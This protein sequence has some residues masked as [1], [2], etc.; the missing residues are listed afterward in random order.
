MSRRQV[1]GARALLAML[2]LAAIGHQFARSTSAGADPMNFFS[3]FTILGNVFVAGVFLA[4]ALRVAER[5]VPTPFEDSVRGA[6]VLYALATGVVYSTLLSHFELGLTLPWVNVQLHYVMP[7]A[8]V[9]DW[10]LQPPFSRLTLAD[11]RWWLLF[12]V[13]Y[14]LYTLVR[15][16]LAYWY[17]Y[18]FLDPHR[19]GGYGSVALVSLGILA[20]MAAGGVLIMMLGNRLRRNVV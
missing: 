12:P 17:P 14:L 4:G 19:A 6:S 9:L 11:V 15:G 10:L 3:Y 16:R 18:P 1:Q 2:T 7:V 20:A 13:A 5:H 8:V